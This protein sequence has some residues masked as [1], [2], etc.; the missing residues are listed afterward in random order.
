M[1]L[2]VE[3]L[4]IEDV[5]QQPKPSCDIP[6]GD[7]DTTGD[8]NE[9]ELARA[10]EALLDEPSEAESEFFDSTDIDSEAGDGGVPPGGI[11]VEPV[12]GGPHVLEPVVGVVA[13]KAKAKAKA[14]AAKA[15][16]KAKAKPK[17]AILEDAAV[18]VVPHS[19]HPTKTINIR[20]DNLTFLKED[21]KLK[22]MSIHCRHPEHT[23]RC[24]MQ[25]T[26]LENDGNDAGVMF[27]CCWPA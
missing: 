2:D 23:T 6:I 27:G 21:L 11:A 12:V 17:E 9:D 13:G 10:I 20:G 18:A 4:A 26:L 5:V 25:R 19:S 3:P 8:A 1:K 7:L 15:K 24:R 14:K 22:K 16:A